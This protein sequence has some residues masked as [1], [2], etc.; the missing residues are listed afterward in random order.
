MK[1]PLTPSRTSKPSAVAE[2]GNLVRFSRAVALSVGVGAGVSFLLLC[3][4]AVLMSVRDLPHSVVVPMSILA[5]TAGTIL[6]GYCC[7]RI[8]R[9]KGLLWGLCCGTVL[10]LLAFFCEL[11][12]L[13]QPIG[14]LALYKFI[15]YAASGMIGGV[16]GVNQKRKV[17][18]R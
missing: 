5:V 15:I 18:V 6:S 7:A 1:K 4:F 16:L 3:A 9:E 14:I 13:G 2:T 8:L 10:F 11:M 17:K 12:L